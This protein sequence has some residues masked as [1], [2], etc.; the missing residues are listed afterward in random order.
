MIRTGAGGSAHLVI[1]CDQCGKAIAEAVDG[2]YRWKIPLSAG[3][4]PKL[5]FFTHKDCADA[6]EKV[7]PER[8][9][10]V[11]DLDGLPTLLASALGVAL[12]EADATAGLLS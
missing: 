11:A 3:S 8:P 5:P 7:H 1:V 2:S 9:W 6:F 10:G 4:P 12:D